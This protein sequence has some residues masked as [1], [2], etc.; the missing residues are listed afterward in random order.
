MK[1][2]VLLMLVN[3]CL[4]CEQGNLPNDKMICSKKCMEEL[5]KCGGDYNM[6]DVYIPRK[7]SK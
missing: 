4:W 7:K 2:N 5:N 3:S 1:P 6:Q